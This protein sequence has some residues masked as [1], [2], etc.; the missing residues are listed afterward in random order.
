MKRDTD[1][2]TLLWLND[3][4]KGK[5]RWIVLLILIQRVQGLT[6]VGYAL[7]LQGI[8][9]SAVGG[10]RDELIRYSVLL[11]LLLLFQVTLRAIYRF[12]EEH[13]KASLENA[14]KQRLFRALLTRDYAAVTA[15]HS[16]EWMNRLTSDTVLVSTDLAGLLPALGG[17]AVRMGA[18]LVALL[19]IEPKFGVLIILGGGLLMLLTLVLRRRLKQFHTRM[20]AADGVVRVFLSERLGSLLTIRAF[21]QEEAALEQ[22]AE[23]MAAHKATRMQKTNFANLC[24]MGMGLAVNGIYA[25]GAIYCGSQILAGAM[26][27][28]TF[29]AV[30]QLI[31]Q[32]QN[33]ITNISGFLPKYY[34]MLASGDRLREVERYEADDTRPAVE[35]IQGFYRQRFTGLALKD[36]CFTYR[37]GRESPELLNGLNLTIQKGEYVAFTGP[38][39]CGKSTVLKLLMCMYPLDSGERN[40]MSTDGPLPLTAGWRELYAYVPQ[41]NQLMNGTIREVVTFGDKAAMSREADI[42]RA[43][44]IACA[45]Q[46]VRELPD[47]LDTMLG[48]RGAGLSEGQMQRIAVARAIFSDRP[49]LLL[50]EATSALDD[51]TEKQLL[52][53]LRA[54]T[55]RTVIIVTHRSAVLDVT[56]T[57]IRFK[58]PGET[59]QSVD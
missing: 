11:V 55:E 2:A 14:L 27:Y 13:T 25:F 30:L 20:Q 42:M 32:V 36:A 53:N 39:G 56:D 28:G 9:D 10:L 44:E 19:A 59:E 35:E 18:A 58:K 48:E 23:R 50:D 24:N 15:T 46:F 26:T 21:G 52:K 37:S 49:I 12:L 22:G 43:L 57:E 8:V 47:G 1:K 5:R 34:A 45:D 33:P 40:V 38:S 3:V 29:T 4:A 17:M 6:A 31:N 7:F 16:G 51:D 54:M 41:G